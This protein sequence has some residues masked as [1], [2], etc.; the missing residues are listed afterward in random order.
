MKGIPGLGLMELPES[1]GEL[2]KIPAHPEWSRE[3]VLCHKCSEARF[4]G[5]KF[6]P[7]DHAQL[8]VFG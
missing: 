4:A 3:I 6:E 7:N 1:V 8:G 2:P 5:L